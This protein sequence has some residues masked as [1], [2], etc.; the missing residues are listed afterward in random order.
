[1]MPFAGG[2]EATPNGILVFS[3]GAAVF[4][5]AMLEREPSLR[6]SVM[7]TLAVALLALLTALENGPV[8]LVVALVLS[9]L[10]DAFLSRDGKRA[11]L[12]GLGSFLLAHVAYAALFWMHG[13]REGLVLHEPMRAAVG[14]IMVAA[15]GILV[16]RL[17]GAV[18]RDLREPVTVY[19]L[20]ILTTGL[21]ALT[22]PGPWIVLGAVAFMASDAL[23]GA[24]KFLLTRDT[25]VRGAM[26]QG[27]W[28]LYYVA[29][30]VITL[31]VLLR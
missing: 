6:R 24:E 11:F 17:R 23:L 14:V 20:A 25:Q 27:V 2:M 28:V 18:P 21:A 22:V 10:G 30:A 9:A 8:L 26:R 19:G 13:E 31:G 1:M 16:A 7:K 5:L 29:Q 4:Y 3:I 12:G 15:T